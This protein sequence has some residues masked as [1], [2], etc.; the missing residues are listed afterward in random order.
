LT[1]YKDIFPNNVPDLPDQSKILKQLDNL[2]TKAELQLQCVRNLRKSTLIVWELLLK[3]S[4]SESERMLAF[5]NKTKREYTYR[6]R[7]K[8]IERWREQIERQKDG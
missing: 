7:L 2:V 8:R 6:V 5:Q 4:L 1:A 3:E